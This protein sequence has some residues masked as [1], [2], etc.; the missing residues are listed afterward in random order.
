MHVVAFLLDRLVFASHGRRLQIL[1]KRT[2]ARSLE[3]P[4]RF[5]KN[6]GESHS[7]K[8]FV[9]LLLT[10]NP[11]AGL[12]PSSSL[13]QLQRSN[14]NY[15]TSRL[16][17]HRKPL[18]LLQQRPWYAGLVS[19]LVVG[20]M[21]TNFG[22]TAERQEFSRTL[23]KKNRPPYIPTYTSNGVS[24]KDYLIPCSDGKQQNGARLYTPLSMVEPVAPLI[25]FVHGGGWCLN[26]CF[27]QPSDSNCAKLCRELRCCVLGID[28]RLAPEHPWPAA[29]EDV[30][31]SLEWLARETDVAPRADR[32][33]IVLIGES[34]GGNL[35][36]CVSQMCRDRLPE[37]IRIA[38]QVLISPCMLA[39]PLRPSRIDPARANGAFLP[40]WSMLWFEEQYAG[41]LTVEELSEQPYAS[42]LAAT[43]LDGLPPLTGVVG[44][45]EVLRDES[46]EYFERLNNAGIDAD[47]Q[48]FEGGFHSFPIFPFGQ[49]EEAWQ[50]VY[51][52]LRSMAGLFPAKPAE[53]GGN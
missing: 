39:R 34:A 26:S 14:P 33:R 23:Y 12:Q 44:G 1:Q 20:P 31:S 38:H 13:M 42:P 28:Y 43:N 9:V 11:A 4:Q 8:T 18:M 25:V 52:R 16:I 5:H 37:G 3:E 27:R 47:W 45:A 7:F 2:H 49:A 19:D 30:Y 32:Q 40:A 15:I 50:Y 46:T 41:K 29:V 48:E 36:A 10:I 22:L 24:C 51:E 17:R 35:A 21:L 53:V 6:I